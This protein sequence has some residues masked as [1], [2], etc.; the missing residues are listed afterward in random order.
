MHD[1]CNA[2]ERYVA[3]INHHVVLQTT[4]NNQTITPVNIT[5]NEKKVQFEHLLNQKFPLADDLKNPTPGYSLGHLKANLEAIIGVPTVKVRKTR[6][7]RY[8]LEVKL[9]FVYEETW[10]KNLN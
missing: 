2:H 9:S 4:T 1:N 8:Q 3:F 10:G 7:S 6:F 5:F